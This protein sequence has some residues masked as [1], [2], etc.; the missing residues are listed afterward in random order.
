MVSREGVWRSEPLQHT[1]ARF[2]AQRRDILWNCIFSL[3]VERECFLELFKRQLSSHAL[4]EC[5]AMLVNFN[6]RGYF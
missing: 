3:V 2:W 6:F 5:V 4:D 1:A